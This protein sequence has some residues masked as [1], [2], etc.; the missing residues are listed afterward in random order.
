MTTELH[1]AFDPTNPGQFYACC[2]L[3]ELFEFL[4]ASTLS[5]FNLTSNRPRTGEFVLTADQP[6]ELSH[7]LKTVASASYAAIQDQDCKAEE[8][9]RP[10]RV[11][12][13][14][15]VIELDWWLDV[16]RLKATA[17]K[18]WAGQVTSARL[19]E[20]LPCRVN[21]ASTPLNLFLL[22]CPTRSKFGVD[23]RSAWN[24]LDFGYSPNEQNQDATTFPAVEVLA[25]FGLQGFRP[26]IDARDAVRYCL[27]TKPLPRLPATLAAAD[28]WEGLP[29]AEFEF[30]IAK[31]GS[32][33]YFTP[34]RLKKRG[35]PSA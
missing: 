30:S 19:F 1:F 35:N 24:S 27:W 31:R 23:P 2:G 7:L 29:A 3:I 4:G 28:G 17:L 32:Y 5:W 25:A 26:E 11:T 33:K 14:T 34:A 16:F 21:T 15:G 8:T 10:V 20:E 22:A 18:G 9:V 6:L 13:Q 12:L